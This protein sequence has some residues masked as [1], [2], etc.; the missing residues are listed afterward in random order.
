MTPPDESKI[1]ITVNSKDVARF[2]AEGYE[3]AELK[4]TMSKPIK[5]DEDAKQAAKAITERGQDNLYFLA[6]DQGGKTEDR[7]GEA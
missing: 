3:I 1:Y 7:R 6:R 5:T 4:I 2:L